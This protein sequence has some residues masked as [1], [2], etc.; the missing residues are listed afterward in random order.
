MEENT[1]T[2]VAEEDKEETDKL[3]EILKKLNMEEKQALFAFA[4]GMKCM[5]RKTDTNVA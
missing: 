2:L 3:Y 1:K 4:L 5:V